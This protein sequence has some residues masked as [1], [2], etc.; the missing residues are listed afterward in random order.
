M[1]VSGTT[2]LVIKL[3]TLLSPRY[4]ML[5]TSSTEFGRVGDKDKNVKRI[6]KNVALILS[7]SLHGLSENPSC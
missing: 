3:P 5:S 1:D 4:S 6:C 7:S 2:I